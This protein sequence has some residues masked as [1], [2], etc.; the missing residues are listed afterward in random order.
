M[1]DNLVSSQ[2]QGWLF[3]E[4]VLVQEILRFAFEGKTCVIKNT[5]ITHEVLRITW[6]LAE[7]NWNK[8][9]QNNLAVNRETN[10]V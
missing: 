4:I 10:G 7:Q 3:S 9:M 1:Q 2:L 6:S 8:A 5:E